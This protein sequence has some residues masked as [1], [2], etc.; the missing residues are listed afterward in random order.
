MQIQIAGFGE[1]FPDAVTDQFLCTS[2]AVTLEKVNR[3]HG[4][5]EEEKERDRES[6]GEEG[7]ER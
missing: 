4:Q 5:E 3:E 6:K 7:E 2:R 1:L